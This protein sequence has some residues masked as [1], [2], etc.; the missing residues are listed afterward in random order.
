MSSHKKRR[1]IRWNQD[2]RM[3]QFEDSNRV[4]QKRVINHIRTLF[5]ETAPNVGS[6]EIPVNQDSDVHS[7][8]SAASANLIVPENSRF[9]SRSANSASGPPVQYRESQISR[10]PKKRTRFVQVR[11][12]S[13]KAPLPT[14]TD[15]V[16]VGDSTLQ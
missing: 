10:I 2:E 6:S 7:T 4:R 14:S 13:R 12:L 16:H 5:L 15:L 3:E 11:E 8:T 9:C 1:L